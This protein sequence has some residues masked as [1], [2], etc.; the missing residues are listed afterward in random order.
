MMRRESS[1][2]RARQYGFT[3]LELIVSMTLTALLLGMLS[4]GMYSVVSDWNRETD[5]LDT[6]IDKSLAMLQIE[7]AMEG[8][9]PHSYIN[10]RKLAR[11]VYFQ[12][13]GNEVRFISTVSPQRYSGLTAWDL[14]SS[15]DKGLQLKL[16]PAF[17]D[18]PDSRFDALA[19]SPLLPGYEARFRYLIQR[20]PQEKEWL[21]E[22]PPEKMQSLPIAIEVLLTPVDAVSDEHEL[23]IVAQVKA[24]RHEDIDPKIPVL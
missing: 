3:L 2:R 18:N 8:A 6:A 21:D 24:W 10:T 5:G 13:T 19:A 4:A 17:S 20:N 11:F 23:E 22:W 15:P 16:T 9:F 7:R 12:G 1:Q 14:I